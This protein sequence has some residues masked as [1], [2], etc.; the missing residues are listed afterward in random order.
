[1]RLAI[2]IS[3]V[4]W[5]GN[6]GTAAP[7]ADIGS[8]FAAIDAKTADIRS[9]RFREHDE[10]RSD[11]PDYS[12]LTTIDST[13][14]TKRK[15]ILVLYHSVRTTTTRITCKVA[16]CPQ[17]AKLDGVAV[18]DTVFNGAVN[19]EYTKSKSFE[20]VVGKAMS[21]APD[22]LNSVDNIKQLASAYGCTLTRNPD[23]KNRGRDAYVIEG[24]GPRYH[25]VATVEMATGLIVD[26]DLHVP[27]WRFSGPLNVH[28]NDDISD[29]HFKF[30]PPPGV[31]VVMGSF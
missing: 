31:K 1:M 13:T 14:E 6:S 20:G 12:E 22:P 15:G 16:S 4:V 29:D 28:L 10:Y 30:T 21:R 3:V 17:R 23:T 2:V 24:K 26:L 18:E 27:G 11:K 7:A 8:A 25:F 5:T 9:I 19:Y